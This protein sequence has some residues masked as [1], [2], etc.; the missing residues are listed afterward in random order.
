MV[1]QVTSIDL[2][3]PHKLCIAFT[4]VPECDSILKYQLWFLLMKYNT[5][6]VTMIELVRLLSR[7]YESYLVFVVQKNYKSGST[8]KQPH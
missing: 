1:L 2:N 6:N 5:I 4:F 8:I 3:N 7:L